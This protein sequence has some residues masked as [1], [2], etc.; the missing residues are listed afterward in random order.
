MQPP[1]AH[2]AAPDLA[3]RAALS[4]L[5]ARGLRVAAPLLSRPLSAR[6]VPPAGRRPLRAGRPPSTAQVRGPACRS[7]LLA[8]F[9]IDALTTHNGTHPCRYILQ[10]RPPTPLTCPDFP[11][12]PVCKPGSSAPGCPG[13]PC[14]QGTYASGTSCLK[15]P[16]GFTTLVLGATSAA[17]CSGELLRP[18]AI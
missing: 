17:N 13:V 10:R 6:T 16:A 18:V 4:V 2:C 3:A 7:I 15:C 11:S 1:A 12:R 5:L 9:S 8:P 14:P